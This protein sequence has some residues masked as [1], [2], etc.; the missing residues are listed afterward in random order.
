MSKLKN[1]NIKIRV[2]GIIKEISILY[3]NS[4][5]FLISMNDVLL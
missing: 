4:V 1:L 5:V 2:T 3:I